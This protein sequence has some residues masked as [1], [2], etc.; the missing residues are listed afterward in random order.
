ML[1]SS[2]WKRTVVLFPENAREVGICTSDAHFSKNKRL[3]PP[4]F[5]KANPHQ[6]ACPVL[7]RMKGKHMF[8]IEMDKQLWTADLNDKSFTLVADRIC[9]AS[10][11]PYC[12]DAKPCPSRAQPT[13][14]RPAVFPQVNGGPSH[15][16]TKHQSQW[17]LITQANASL[18]HQ[19]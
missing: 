14:N 15:R 8:S 10:S 4:L 7:P 6:Q 3:T 13:E 16:W 5:G 18:P 19:E 17:T 11:T 1:P 12:D 2:T 9:W